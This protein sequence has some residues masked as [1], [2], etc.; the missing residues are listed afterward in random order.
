M[1]ASGAH[2]EFYSADGVITGKDYAGKWR[3]SGDNMCF[4]YGED[5]EACRLVRLDDDLLS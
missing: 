3:V 5:P 2:T 1:I 4:Q